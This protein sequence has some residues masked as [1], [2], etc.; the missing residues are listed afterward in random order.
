MEKQPKYSIY[1]EGHFLQSV[2]PAELRMIHCLISDFFNKED[3]IPVAGMKVNTPSENRVFIAKD[4]CFDSRTR[5]FQTEYSICVDDDSLTNISD[6]EL[7]NLY[8]TLQSFLIQS[9]KFPAEIQKDSLNQVAKDE[10]ESNIE[11][12]HETI[13]NYLIHPCQD[14]PYISKRVWL[15]DNH[16]QPEKE[17]GLFTENSTIVNISRKQLSALQEKIGNLLNQLQTESKK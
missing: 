12:T 5:D 8:L 4:V 15:K 13:D 2:S 14:S 11:I 17:Y 1:A 10:Q 6:G 9:E 7:V 3:K 16:I